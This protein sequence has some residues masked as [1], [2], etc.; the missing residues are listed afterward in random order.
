MLYGLLAAYAVGLALW[1]YQRIRKLDFSLRENRRK[2][3]PES[4]SESGESSWY[5]N[6]EDDPNWPDR[7]DPVWPKK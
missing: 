6:G 2:T 7:Y 1:G 4:P 5:R 3:H